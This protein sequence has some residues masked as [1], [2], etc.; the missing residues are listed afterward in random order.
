M[1]VSYRLRY[2]VTLQQTSDKLK[3]MYVCAQNMER[4]RSNEDSFR[5]PKRPDIMYTYTELFEMIVRVLTTCH[6]QYT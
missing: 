2:Y 1:S 4:R 6:T 5:A 3:D